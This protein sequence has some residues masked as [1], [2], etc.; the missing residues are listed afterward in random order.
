MTT[1]APSVRR[2]RKS[3]W[4]RLITPF[5][6]L[7]VV[8]IA[9][10]L[11][12]RQIQ[13]ARAS[14]TA[15]I[16]TRPVTRGTL[17]ATVAAAGNI[18]SAAQVYLNFSSGGIV[19]EV[20]VKEGDRV[21]AG[22]ALIR[23]QSDDLELAV[24]AQEANLRNAKLKLE[25]TK[26]GAKNTD[27]ISAQAR[28]DAANAALAKL[29]AGPT[30]QDLADAQS[31]LVSAQAQF[32][33]TRQGSATSADIAASQASLASAQANLDK[34]KG[35]ATQSAITDA[36]QK[37]EQAKNSLWAA[38]S[39]RDS[40]CGR[41]KNPDEDTSCN[42]ARAQVNNAELNVQSAQNALNTLLAG[43][44]DSDV[45]QAQASVTQAQANL[46]KLTTVN[47][48]DLTV[49]QQNV[50]QAQTALDKLRQPPT[51]ADLA[52]AQSNVT[53]A[54]AALD[55]LNAGPDAL[56]LQVAQTG[57]DQAEVSLKQAQLKLR[58]ATIFA[59]F[60]GVITQVTVVPGQNVAGS[61]NPI[62]IADLNNLQVVTNVSELDR[63]RLKVGQEVQL[64]LEALSGVN[65]RG[66]VVSI[67]PAG[68][69]QQGVVNFPMTV[70]LINPDA[71][72]APGMTANMNV[73]IEQK[74][75]VLLVPNRAIRTQ[76][77]TRSVSVLFEGQQIPVTVQTGM[78]DGTNTEISGAGIKEGDQVVLT[79]TTSTANRAGGPGGF[80]PGGGG[81]PVFIGR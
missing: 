5:I 45:A 36:Q 18:Q 52:Q 25:Q 10:A 58:Q 9:I 66:Q 76:G 28:L 17:T 81:G 51:D 68:V 37:I 16:E 71:S 46:Q 64:T 40:T 15:G 70:R 26:A 6:V 20:L 31:R 73:V 30:P 56:A 49:A 29:K 2:S 14:A 32:T 42:S 67:S 39:S 1:S 13:G 11:G 27:V 77:R 19:K 60:D 34:V 57:V 59:P 35:G 75:D 23:V 72:V 61:G 12:Y 54:Q 4:R 43:P 47:P 79:S 55:A 53:Q 48:N 74:S 3:P 80:G 69:T 44:T 62:Q 38:Q 22:D 7:I 65:L 8:G 63:S 50:N 41:A 21:K 78:T 33:K 24:A